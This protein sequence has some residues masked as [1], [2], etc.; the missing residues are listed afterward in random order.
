MSVRAF[1]YSRYA[2]E[3]LVD[4]VHLRASSRSCAAKPR[5]GPP[6]AVVRDVQRQGPP[7]HPVLRAAASSRLQRSG[8]RVDD[9]TG[10]FSASE[11][12]A[13]ATATAAGWSAARTVTM[14]MIWLAV[15]ALTMLAALADAA[16]PAATANPAGSAGSPAVP[17]D[18]DGNVVAAG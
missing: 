14:L 10:R 3:N 9:A 6:D 7:G 1:A 11:T 2:A 15:C 17:V 12:T 16:C 18:G 5:D 4:A 8:Q 13:R